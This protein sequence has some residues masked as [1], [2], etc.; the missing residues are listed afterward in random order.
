MLAALTLFLV[1]HVLATK[2]IVE[3]LPVV[4]E[5]N[6]KTIET[7]DISTFY[8]DE[9]PSPS[10]VEPGEVK[11]LETP[12]ILHV[13]R[14]A[15]RMIDIE[16]GT[17]ELLEDH[18][19]DI[20][21]FFSGNKKIPGTRPY[22]MRWAGTQLDK[23]FPDLGDGRSF[24]LGQV[25]NSK[26]QMFDLYLKGSGPT[27]A[28]SPSDRGKGRI[29]LPIAMRDYIMSEAAYRLGIPVARS[30]ALIGSRDIIG[31]EEMA[32]T[33]ATMVMKLAPTNLRFGIFQNLNFERRFDDI[34]SLVDFS[35]NHY[36]P[37][38]L[39]IPKERPTWMSDDD[40][41]EDEFV[42]SISSHGEC[43]GYRYAEWLKRIFVH[44]MPLVVSLKTYAMN[45]GLLSTENLNILGVPIDLDRSCL[46]PSFLL[47]LLLLLQ[48]SFFVDH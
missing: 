45:L 35:I 42:C 34:R 13:N 32:T 26:G 24:V 41:D 15:F 46:S 2:A 30:L 37:D 17:D 8:A 27:K 25:T 28:T 29:P 21:A 10:V 22:S 4:P 23:V 48:V 36:F 12:Y 44:Q 16:I 3:D 38:L 14:D 40:D 18:I 47:L 11:P 6:R 9:L 20:L 39:Q 1:A 7:L 19:D 5:E 43:P 33:T 31:E